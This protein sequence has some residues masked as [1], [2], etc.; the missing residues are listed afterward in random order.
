MRG[1]G[2]R[3]GESHPFPADGMT[4]LQRLGMKVH[5]VGRLAIKGIAQNRTVHT[6]GMGGVYTQLVGSA[7]LRIV[8]YGSDETFLAVDGQE[9]SVA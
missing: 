3:T 9:S 4:E 6:V 7:C 1:E 5:A 2:R 8:G